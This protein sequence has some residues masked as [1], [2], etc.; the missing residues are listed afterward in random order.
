MF[1]N[2][3]CF[4][5][6]YTVLIL[7]ALL[8]FG[9]LSPETVLASDPLTNHLTNWPQMSDINED[10][11]DSL[12]PEPGYPEDPCLDHEDHDLPSCT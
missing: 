6:K 5:W 10:S 8:A 2:G 3:N 12:L 11:A 9:A 4:I 1:R 7:S